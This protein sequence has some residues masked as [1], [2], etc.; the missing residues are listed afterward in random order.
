MRTR[1]RNWSKFIK[2][3]KF[4][5]IDRWPDKRLHLR[6][7]E[8]TLQVL[9]GKSYASVGSLFGLT[10]QR[11]MTISRILCAKLYERNFGELYSIAVNDKKYYRH[12]GMKMMVRL[13]HNE[14]ISWMIKK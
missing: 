4:I 14:F 1:L 2:M 10:R 9:A 11:V 3:S 6:N 5:P 12:K 13:Y 7:I 8:I